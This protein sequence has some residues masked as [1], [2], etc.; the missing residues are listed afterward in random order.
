MNYRSA[1]VGKV[2]IN[3]NLI[4]MLSFLYF[5][6]H[7]H[8]FLLCTGFHR[9]GATYHATPMYPSSRSLS[10]ALGASEEP[11]CMWVGIV[12]VKLPLTAALRGNQ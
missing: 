12:A 5:C 3:L 10:P 4:V 1:T 9:A 11:S 7:T 2:T 6:S 8:F